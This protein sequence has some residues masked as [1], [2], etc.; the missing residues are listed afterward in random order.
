MIQRVPVKIQIMIQKDVRQIVDHVKNGLVNKMLMDV[1]FMITSVV[2]HQDL[3]VMFITGVVHMI[4][5]HLVV[6]VQM[7][8]M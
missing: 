1:G 8:G 2:V 5:I 4:L 7:H 6:I 3:T